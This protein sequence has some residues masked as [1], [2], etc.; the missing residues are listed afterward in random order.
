MVFSEEKRDNLHADGDDNHYVS[1]SNLMERNT[2]VFEE[3]SRECL[4]SSHYTQGLI[5]ENHLE[6]NYLSSIGFHN[7]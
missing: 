6:S 1:L 2:F 5:H 4:P 7:L 3:K